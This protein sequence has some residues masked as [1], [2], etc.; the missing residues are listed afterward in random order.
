VPLADIR[1]GLPPKFP[2]IGMAKPNLDKELP[3]IASDYDLTVIDGAPRVNELA[4]SATRMRTSRLMICPRELASLRSSATLARYPANQITN[5]GEEHSQDRGCIPLVIS[6]HQID[7][8][9][10]AS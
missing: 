5:S 4:R 8:R 1:V 7:G 10:F 2:V 3:G 6:D 9:Y